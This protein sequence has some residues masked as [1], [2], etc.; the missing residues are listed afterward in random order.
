MIF[1][2]NGITVDQQDVLKA[3]NHGK[4]HVKI[5]F[6]NTLFDEF[7]IYVGASIVE[8]IKAAQIGDY[9]S[10]VFDGY[11]SVQKDAVIA[12]ANMLNSTV[13]DNMND[14]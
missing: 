8:G 11:S 9:N 10:S 14:Y 13:N 1:P 12:V 5:Y 4:S 3:K 6:H 7:D 2:Y